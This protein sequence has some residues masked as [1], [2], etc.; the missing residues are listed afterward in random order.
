MHDVHVSTFPEYREYLQDYPEEFVQLFSTILINDTAFVR[1]E[2]VH[3]RDGL[4]R[5][6]MLMRPDGVDGA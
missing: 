3:A 1:D 4:R 6:I 2:G 5:G